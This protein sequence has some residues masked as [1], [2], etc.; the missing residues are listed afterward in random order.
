MA[1]QTI[2]VDTDV[3]GGIGDGSSRANAFDNLRTALSTVAYDLVAAG[4][5]VIF[6]CFGAANDSGVGGTTQALVSAA[7]GWVTSETNDILIV[8]DTG[9]LLVWD[10]TKYTLSHVWNYNGVLELGVPHVNVSN[11]QL[12]NVGTQT[13]HVLEATGSFSISGCI[14]RNTNG[15]G[16]ALQLA[17]ANGSKAVIVNNLCYDTNRF[18][19]IGYP[20]ASI[21][22]VICNNTVVGCTG[23]GIKLTGS[24][25]CTI[26]NN[27]SINNGALD[28]NLT[29]TSTTNTAANISSDTSSPNAAFQSLT[30][31]F[32]DAANDNYHLDPSDTVAKAQ[33]VNL[34]SDPA[35]SFNVDAQGD[36]RGATWDIGADQIT[37]PPANTDPQ[38]DSPIS[39]I[40]IPG[41]TTG[42]VLDLTNH[43]SDIDGDPLTYG[44]TPALPT[45]LVLDTAT[46]QVTGNGS[47]TQ[48]AAANY[49]F[50][51]DDSRGG[52]PASVVASI[53]V[54]APAFVI[55][56]YDP[57]M[58]RLN[59]WQL[60]CSNPAVVPT[61]ENSNITSGNDVIPCT[62]VMGTGPYV[63]TFAVGDLSKQTDATGYAW[64]LNVG[65]QTLPLGVIPLQ[66]Q[67]GWDLI[68]LNTPSVLE[69]S[70]LE[71]YTGDAPVTGDH[72]EWRVA[73]VLDA[74]VTFSVEETAEWIV[75][76]AT[77]GDWVNP[78]VVERRVVQQ[79]GDI[80]ATAVLTFHATGA[81]AITI[82]G[83][84]P[85]YVEWQGTYTDQGATALDSVDGDITNDISTVNNV[86]TGTLGAQTVDYSVTNSIGVT[87]NVSR[88]VVVRDTVAPEITL[89][90]GAVQITQ[91]ES[92]V[93][94]G[95]TAS[96]NY[97]GDIT[98]NVNVSG[99]VGSAIG[100]YT[101][102]YNV[103][104]SSGNP[105]V[106]RT[107][108]VSV[109]A[110]ANIVDLTVDDSTSS[111]ATDSVAVSLVNVYDLTVDGSSS[112]TSVDAVDLDVVFPLF[113]DSISSATTLDSVDVFQ[114]H[115]LLPHGMH[116]TSKTSVDD[117]ALQ[118]YGCRDV[119]ARV[120]IDSD[121]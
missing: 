120:I 106:T 33:G 100:N 46:G 42:L 105:A 11:C 49:T 117:V 94:Q 119:G 41:N 84:N 62:G 57:N 32:V 38:V 72:L 66:L 3:V 76:E 31:V 19:D 71:G 111:T 110:A 18:C 91:G 93:E 112:R 10:D 20:D 73:S 59:D 8:G 54:T 5:S 26:K 64:S 102:S 36:V 104:D 96:D 89:I 118:F 108:V 60:T 85:A 79:N 50:T 113:T 15:R 27:I 37:A 14:L 58:Q 88:T 44:V 114:E 52:T 99:F 1:V 47:I 75:G 2:Y 63:L 13:S 48:T 69:G 7:D 116:S 35:Y 22:I 103:S 82:V 121:F 107:R 97:D 61:P 86:N 53:E 90:G 80:G 55:D 81:A 30:P 83:D 101:L 68:A 40:S 65:A 12:E 9:G 21:E 29:G 4:D 98:N 16:N 95:F 109:V 34:N 45:G 17:L 67:T 51:A 23:E 6:A 28:Y 87:T 25:N 24:S 70:L 77:S 74:G 56:S 43:V 92:Y 115:T 39:N 78:I